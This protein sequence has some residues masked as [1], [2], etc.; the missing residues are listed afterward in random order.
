MPLRLHIHQN[1]IT[2]QYNCLCIM[3]LPIRACHAWLN[4]NMVASR[5]GHVRHSL[6]ECSVKTQ[7]AQTLYSHGVCTLTHY[8]SFNELIFISAFIIDVHTLC[9]SCQETV[10]FNLLFLINCIKQQLFPW[11]AWLNTQCW[12]NWFSFYV[13]AY[14]AY[15]EILLADTVYMQAVRQLI[16]CS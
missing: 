12:V 8:A 2:Y 3:H 10:I 9:R 6:F 11:A 1:N 15:A 5:L 16:C 4:T 13:F 7:D 14:E